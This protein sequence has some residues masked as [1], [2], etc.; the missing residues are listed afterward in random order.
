MDSLD[1]TLRPGM[2][3]AAA[4]PTVLPGR[5]AAKQAALRLVS[6]WRRLLIA[7]GLLLLSILGLVIMVATA[8]Q[9][10]REPR[11]ERTW[12][13]DATVA[14]RTD[15]QPTVTLLGTLVP[16]R[17][18]D[19]RALVAG[20]VAEVSPAFRTG[21]IVREGDLL[22]SI[23]ALDYELVR[24]EVAAQLAEARA[25]LDEFRAAVATERQQMELR[26]RELAR[27]QDLFKKGAIAAPRMEQ[28]QLAT[29]QQEQAF[30]AAEARVRQQEAV[31]DRLTAALRKAE[32]DLQRTR[33][34]A[35]FDGFVGQ[36]NAE[37]GMRLSPADR[38]ATLSG[39]SGLEARV[40]L[41]TD[42]YGRLAADGAGIIGRQAE[43]IWAVGGEEFRYPATIARVIDRMDTATG[44][45]GIFVRLEGDFLEAPLRPG[46]FVRVA[47]PDRAYSGVIQL[48]VNALHGDDRVYVVNGE[49]RLDARTVEI[50]SRDGG[51]VYVRTGIEDGEQVVTTRFQEIAP[52]LKVTVRGAAAQETAAPADANGNGEVTP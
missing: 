10:Q 19:L 9:V 15:H 5:S 14:H 46:A 36:V 44:G 40:N 43:V 13:V 8:P 29:N 25:R 1:T 26:Q 12:A 31:V 47:V 27:N 42:V 4:Y 17:N 24:T 38:V 51:S 37:T 39:S 18:A 2:A 32:T 30:R 16:G 35:P 41:P 6:R 28:T 50:A 49:G 22:L 33:L 23:E 7:L 52:G 34:V 20:T 48:P 11:P 3:A 21:G 45:V